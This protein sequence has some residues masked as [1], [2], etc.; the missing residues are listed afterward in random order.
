MFTLPIER[1]TGE[2][3][4]APRGKV[5]KVLGLVIEATGPVAA[6]GDLA[7]I[8]VAR[9]DARHVLAEIVGFRDGRLLLMPLG[10]MDGVAP[11][12]E[13]EPLGRPLTVPTGRGLLGRVLDGLGRPIDGRGRLGGADT[14]SHRNAPPDPL[15]RRR[16]TE[17]L[18]TGVRAIDGLLTVGLGQRIGIFAGSGVGKSTLL[19]MIARRTT[20]EV[21]VIGLIGE[22]GRE[23]REFI[24]RDLGA[25]GLA[26]SV[27][28]IATSDAP[29]QIRRQAAF[30][31][32]AIAEAF[33]DDGRRVLLMMDSLTRFATAQREV[34]LAI[35]EPPT[36]R[37]YT[38]SVFAILPRLLERAGT[39]PG[40]G[41]ITGLY[42]IL[43]EGDDHNEPVAD[44][45]RSILDGHIVL[46][47]DLAE[48]GHY[49]AIDVLASVSRCMPDVAA[50]AHATDAQALR[51]LLAAHREV[52]PLLALGA[53]RAGSLPVTDRAIA[54]W[55]AIEGFLRQAVDDAGAFEQTI[56]RMANTVDGHGT[57][58]SVVGNT[59]GG[60]A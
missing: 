6:V 56:V 45:A 20:A 60:A 34:G 57:S 8:G 58:R 27:L 41:A 9:G 25:E 48:R 12:A 2:A 47:R 10:E 49:P 37:G 59:S 26:R 42:T 50:P 19:G 55:P 15:T 33:R 44:A 22:R 11:G 51:A 31:A 17:P 46:S 36:T 24:E 18:P 38:P 21:N 32:T 54:A 14:V 1:L 35:G 43:V 30:T 39:S 52:E 23:V 4:L 13:I 5:V 16:V 28:V 7:R 3:L 53:Y 29:P 40:T